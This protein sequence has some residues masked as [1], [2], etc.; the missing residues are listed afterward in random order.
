MSS[1]LPVASKTERGE[2]DQVRDGQIVD[3]EVAHLGE[4]GHHVGVGEHGEDPRGEVEAVVVVA[5]DADDERPNDD[6]AAEG[7]LRDE[8]FVQGIGRRQSTAMSRT[9]ESSPLLLSCRLAFSLVSIYDSLT[10]FF[11]LPIPRPRMH[12]GLRCRLR[13][14]RRFGPQFRP[15]SLT[16]HSLSLSGVELLRFR[17]RPGSSDPAE[18]SG[19]TG[20]G[21][22]P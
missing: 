6:E 11:F 17:R 20:S 15:L 21:G 19:T 9:G 22:S 14:S 3:G 7:L 8:K 16:F 10:K 4:V 5:P 13:I 12:R 18:H 1:I 2:E